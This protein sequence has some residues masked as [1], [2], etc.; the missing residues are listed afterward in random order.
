MDGFVSTNQFAPGQGIVP[1]DLDYLETFTAQKYPELLGL[2]SHTTSQDHSHHQSAENPHADSSSQEV[3]PLIP[4]PGTTSATPQRPETHSQQD[5]LLS[6]HPQ[7]RILVTEAE[8]SDR[9]K[10]SFVAKSIAVVQT[11]WFIVQLIERWATHQPRSQLEIL[12]VAYAVLNILVY[13]LWWK[14]PY[15]VDEPIHVSGRAHDSDRLRTIGLTWDLLDI[16]SDAFD[17]LTDG[18]RQEY[19]WL[20]LPLVGAMFGGLHCLAWWFHFPTH[21]EAVL[22]RVCA[23]YC[24][25][26]PVGIAVIMLVLMIFDGCGIEVHD[27]VTATLGLSSITVYIIC[28][29]TL[30]GITFSCLRASPAGVFE[31]TNWT[32]F[33]PHIS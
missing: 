9:S 8:I 32:K 10:S 1:V 11:I 2:T 7:Y 16:L 19:G 14:K 20:L 31:A 17:S 21:T 30:V 28:R 24:T 33:F 26:S 25:V 6:A 29:L 27:A 18:I 4:F 23:V 13:L 12:T 3:L 5:S 15:N 22:W